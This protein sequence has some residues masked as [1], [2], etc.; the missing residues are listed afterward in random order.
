MER[1][2]PA[3]KERG[4]EGERER[5]EREMEKMDQEREAI[6]RLLDRHVSLFR[7]AKALRLVGFMGISAG[8]RKD[9]E[10]VIVVLA[11]AVLLMGLKFACG[12]L[13]DFIEV[14]S[15]VPFA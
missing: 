15:R 2:C 3:G 5:G 7:P 4:G 6:C 11:P 14:S 13:L 10:S 8:V 9:V 12:S 1:V